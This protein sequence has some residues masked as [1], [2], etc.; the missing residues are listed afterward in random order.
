[1][2]IILVSTVSTFGPFRPWVST[3][4]SFYNMVI[5]ISLHLSRN[6][7]HYILSRSMA[8]FSHLH[9]V[10]PYVKVDSYISQHL[11]TQIDKKKTGKKETKKKQFIAIFTF[12]SL[13][14]FKFLYIHIQCI[15]RH[16]YNRLYR[17][18]CAVLF[19]FSNANISVLSIYLSFATTWQRQTNYLSINTGN[20]SIL[21]SFCWLVCFGVVDH[22]QIFYPVWFREPS[23]PEAGSSFRN[24][25]AP[26]SLYERYVSTTCS[27]P[28]LSLMHYGI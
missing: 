16:S 7:L 11:N 27:A 17:V 21:L 6:C 23:I 14:L 12:Y 5:L 4:S 13:S 26:P 18:I 20:V 3:V 9:N 2:K 1:M 15:T 22:C 19:N 25:A 10:L 8:F 24:P 28:F